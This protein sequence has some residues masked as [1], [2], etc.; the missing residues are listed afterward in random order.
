MFRGD[1]LNG[2]RF[3]TARRTEV[4]YEKTGVTVEL[5]VLCIYSYMLGQYLDPSG[6]MLVRTSRSELIVSERDSERTGIGVNG[7]RRPLLFEAQDPC[8]IRETN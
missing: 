4:S 2:R 8:S 5:L 1:L 6:Y 7:S 3:H